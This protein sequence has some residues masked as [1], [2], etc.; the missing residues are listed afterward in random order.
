MN[1]KIIAAFLG[2]VALTMVPFNTKAQSTLVVNIKTAKISWDWV[3]GDGAPADAFNVKCGKT[4]GQYTKNTAISANV[5][6]APILSVIDGFGTWFCV[7]EAFNDIGTS[8][9]TNEVTFRA[10]DIPL[11]PKNARIE[12]T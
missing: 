1:P 5:R 9:F 3:Q 7:V 8:T 2:V 11:A 10:G 6:S 12:T 4:S